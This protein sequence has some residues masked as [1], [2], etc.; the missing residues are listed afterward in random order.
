MRYTWRRMRVS[1]SFLL[2]W[3]LAVL[4][5][6]HF[7]SA[8][9]PVA[10]GTSGASATATAPA[11]ASTQEEVSDDPL[12]RG[13]PHG[14]VLGFVKAA[15]NGD[16]A[17]AAEYLD[18]RQHGDLA[19]KLAEQLKAVLDRDSSIDLTK[20]SRKPE[21][22]ES[23]PQQP[24]RELIGS[25]TS[26]T[27]TISIYLD[28]EKRGDE[29][30]VWLF[31][32]QT[33]QQIPD[34]YENLSE[35]SPLEQKLPGWLRAQFLATPV[36]RWLVLLVAIPV[37]IF[38]GSWINRLARPV[39]KKV[40]RHVAG[41]SAMD[42]V[43]SL[44]APL[45]LLLLAIVLF[46]FGATS[47]SL[48]GRA[49]WHNI[50]LLVLV[51]AITWLVSRT[52]GLIGD[53]SVSRL[54]RLQASDKIALAGLIGRLSQILV[55][56]VGALVI[57]QMRGVNLTAAL[58]GLGIGGLAVAFAAQKTLEN[59]FGGIMII[60]DRPLRI[61]D[62]CKIGS[63]EGFVL[64][65]GLRSTRIRTFN[66]TIVTIPN[67]QLSTMNVENYTV[68]DKYWFHHIVNL[69]Y[70]TTAAQMEAVLT[71]IRKLLEDEPSVE[72]ATFRVSFIAIGSVSDDVEVS[73]YIFTENVAGF[74]A[75][76]ES[77]LLR[78][79][80]IVESA[81]AEFSLPTQVTKLV[82]AGAAGAVNLQTPPAKS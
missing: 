69:K 11:T 38:L 15:N 2:R 37:I 61:G 32:A 16:Y 34:A 73:A 50:G 9:V 70:D 7:T 45:R 71:G 81:G 39:L 6:A 23:D 25:T 49:F 40:A 58:T 78:I 66:R 65:I 5:L 31:S 36:W 82:D 4:L 74:F 48:L 47:P 60:S 64:D 30:P 10:P 12:G 17:T 14:A 13:T 56:T 75:L 29:P 55:V 76:Q 80:S 27:G 54:K 41:E 46:I 1:I 21:G 59:L 24:N 28:R 52:V 63:V 33:L 72:T 44:R 67:G 18:T 43:R 53:L 68:R 79:L 77:L 42:H 51:V 3:L 57:L 19:S 62:Q 35:P 8:Q 26:K 22:S 20:L